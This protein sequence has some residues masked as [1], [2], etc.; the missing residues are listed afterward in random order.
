MFRLYGFFTQ[1]SL[2]TLYVLEETG[3]EF[4]F[5]FVSDT[6]YLMYV[7]GL[8]DNDLLRKAYDAESGTIPQESHVGKLQV[9][10]C[11]LDGKPIENM[12]R[13]GVCWDCRYPYQFVT[14]SCKPVASGPLKRSY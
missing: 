13:D 5:E 2:K 10:L 11:R 6:W 9:S 3:V 7:V 1:N 14:D 12:R 8:V 4:E